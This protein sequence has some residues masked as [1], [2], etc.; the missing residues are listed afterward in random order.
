MIDAFRS[1]NS[2]K[3]V[4]PLGVP[5]FFALWRLVPFLAAHRAA[6]ISITRRASA[7]RV[8]DAVTRSGLIIGT[9]RAALAHC[10]LRRKATVS[11]IILNFVRRIHHHAQV[12]FGMKL[13]QR[14]GF[15]DAVPWYLAHLSPPRSGQTGPPS[16]YFG[17]L[18]PINNFCKFSTIRVRLSVLFRLAALKKRIRV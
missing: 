12:P 3:L 8:A 11:T 2:F 13:G 14:A 7:V 4:R 9:S 6:A 17:D 10:A 18:T 1:P 15:D 5:A 16:P